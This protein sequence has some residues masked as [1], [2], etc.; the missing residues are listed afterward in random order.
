MPFSASRVGVNEPVI[1]AAATIGSPGMS[2][3]PEAAVGGD[4][5]RAALCGET[6]AKSRLAAWRSSRQLADLV[7]EEQLVALQ[8]AQL[9]PELVAGPGGFEAR[10]QLLR[11]GEE[12]AITLLAGVERPARLQAL[13]REQQPPQPE[14]DEIGD[15]RV[16][17]DAE[18]ERG[19]D[20]ERGNPEGR[21]RHVEERSDLHSEHGDEA[22]AAALLDAPRDDEEDG[23]GR[24]RGADRARPP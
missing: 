4:H 9:G 17:D 2:P 23:P 22:R 3:V 21:C 10:D 15:P 7:G 13:P 12:D 20:D 5:D 19:L 11:G 8:P 16:L 1:S 18:R 14:L 6:S 24:G